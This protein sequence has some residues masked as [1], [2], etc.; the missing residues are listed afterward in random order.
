MKEY[1]LIAIGTGSAMPI[2]DAVLQENPDTRIAIIDRDEPGGICLTRGCIPSKMLLYPAELVR[3]IERATAFGIDASLKGIDFRRVMERMRETVDRDVVAIRKALE[4]SPGVDY[5]R[6]IAS[7]TAPYTLTVDGTEVHAKKILLCTGSRPGIP[8]VAGLE[9]VPYLTSDTLLGLDTLP[10]TVAIIGGGYIAAEYGHFLAAMGS[11]VTVIG[12]NP[13]FIPEEEPEVSALAR[14]VLGEHLTIV[15]DQEVRSAENRPGGKVGLVARDRG[16]GEETEYVADTVLVASGRSSNTDILHP[17]RGGVMTD[18]RGWIEVDDHLQTSQPG[19]WALG[20]ANGKYLFKHVANYEARIVYFNAVLG[21]RVRADYR[22]VPH[23]VFTWPEIAAVGMKEREAVEAYGADGISIGFQRY[24][25]TAKG[26]AMGVRD[27]FVKVI[28]ENRSGHVLGAHIIGPSA[29]VLIQEVVTLMYTDLNAR[30][31][32]LAS[33]HIHPALSEV[34][35][36]AFSSLMSPAKY[37]RLLDDY[38][39]SA[40]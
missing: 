34:V 40:Q 6:A 12:R 14:K 5:Y 2:V 32:V 31:L 11:K 3:E 18:A 10:P 36:R 15:T 37:R 8:P 22:V 26:E 9:W 25:D 24:Q 13:Q 7:F 16:T 21:E 29:S 30:A 39:L 23:A 33:M 1:D 4:E 35:Q 20:D 38:G 19:V 28:V 27:G 17:E